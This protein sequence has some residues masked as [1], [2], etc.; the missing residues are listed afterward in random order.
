MVGM[1]DAAGILICAP[2]VGYMESHGCDGLALDITH[3]RL[4]LP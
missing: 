1:R 4:E 3:H 2:M